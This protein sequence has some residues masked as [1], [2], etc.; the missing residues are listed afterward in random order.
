MIATILAEWRR[1]VRDEQA[2][3]KDETWLGMT[4]RLLCKQL[5]CKCIIKKRTGRVISPGF[6]KRWIDLFLAL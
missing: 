3:D 1:D 2:C 6:G 5:L 4:G